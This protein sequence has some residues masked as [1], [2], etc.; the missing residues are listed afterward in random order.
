MSFARTS[1]RMTANNIDELLDG[2]PSIDDRAC[3]GDDA[4]S[5]ERCRTVA[6][7]DGGAAGCRILAR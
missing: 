7:L 6:P 2:E 1:D 5:A 3:S 4:G